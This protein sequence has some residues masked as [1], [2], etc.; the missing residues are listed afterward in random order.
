MGRRV[1]NAAGKAGLN[2]RP[3]QFI[4][5]PGYGFLPC[6]IFS[7]ADGYGLWFCFSRE[8]FQYNALWKD[9]SDAG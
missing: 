2:D 5:E 8:F 1:E 3:S 6:P 4:D 9:T 7:A